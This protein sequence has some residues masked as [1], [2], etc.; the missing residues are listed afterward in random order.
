M[1][2]PLSALIVDDENVPRKILMDYVP[3]TDLGF[4]H[5]LEADD[6]SSAFDIALIHKPNL[7]ISDIK[8]PDMDGIRLAELVREQLPLC[9]FVLLSGYSDKQYFK[10]AIK[11]K[12]A[13]YLEKPIDLQEVTRVIKDIAEEL[14]REDQLSDTPAAY[15]EQQLVLELMD[16]ADSHPEILKRL[17]EMKPLFSPYAPCYTAVIKLNG[18]HEREKISNL[19][20]MLKDALSPVHDYCLWTIQGDD[21]CIVHGTSA[22]LEHKK[23]VEASLQQFIENAYKYTGKHSIFIT[24]GETVHSI[25]DLHHSYQSAISLL[26]KHFF[27]GGR[28]IVW[29]SLY[30]GKTYTLDKAIVSR[31]EKYLRDAETDLAKSLISQAGTEM[32]MCE[33]T[34]HEYIRSVF[35]QF[36]YSLVSAADSRN[37]PLT[38]ERNEHILFRIAR[39]TTL[40]DLIQDML[41]TIDDYQE[42]L[43]YSDSCLNSLERLNKYVYEHYCDDD[44]SITSI[45]DHLNL[46]STYLCLI[47]KRSTNKTI[48]QHIT[49]LRMTK[50]KELLKNPHLRLQDVAQQIGYKDVKYFTKVFSNTYGVRPKQYQE[51][52]IHG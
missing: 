21:S 27:K 40:D 28:G 42:Q 7:I 32:K 38:H 5:V 22:L 25:F 36:A 49:A 48:N 51:S 26:K 50:A 15:S 14:L 3:W 34:D 19:F 12:V 35:C 18:V 45:A 2:Q 52:Q 4:H 10:S 44:I 17:Y 9:R 23:S 41:V 37:I 43:H 24:V 33:L 8:M 6:G 16:P 29:H 46:T 20:T 1:N 11:L 31:L 13:E 47:F 30:E 39:H